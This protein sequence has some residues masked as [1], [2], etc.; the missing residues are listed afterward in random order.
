LDAGPRRQ[1]DQKRDDKRSTTI[2]VH[3]QSRSQ[4][5]ERINS[6]MKSKVARLSKVVP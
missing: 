5:F 4:N 1:E 6:C 3:R 2:R